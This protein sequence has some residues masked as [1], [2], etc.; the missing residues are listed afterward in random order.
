MPDPKNV[1]ALMG[2]TATSSLHRRKIMNDAP[3]DRDK[4]IELMRTAKIRRDNLI[5]RRKVSEMKERAEEADVERDVLREA[6]KEE[7][8]VKFIDHLIKCNDEGIPIVEI[9][10]D[11]ANLWME[12]EHDELGS[13]RSFLRI[14]PHIID[15][16]T[17]E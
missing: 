13:A 10:L 16:E 6:L 4:Q 3:L 8:G 9:W 17:S 2:E 12:V 7:I 15:A 5:K 11:G 1:V 14:P